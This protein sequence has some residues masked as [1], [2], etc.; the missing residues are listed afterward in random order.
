MSELPLLPV[1]KIFDCFAKEATD[2]IMAQ[3]AIIENRV[4]EGKDKDAIKQLKKTVGLMQIQVNE[5][6][7]AEEKFRRNMFEVAK[8]R[9]INATAQDQQPLQTSA[10]KAGDVRKIRQP[11]KKKQ[12]NKK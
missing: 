1:A 3:I 12:R 7:K 8:I 5:M 10:Y 11:P 9:L 4:A 6:I 2:Q